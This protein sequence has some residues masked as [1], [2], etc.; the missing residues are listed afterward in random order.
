MTYPR[1]SLRV[2]HALTVLMLLSVLHLS[3]L[4]FTVHLLSL[5]TPSFLSKTHSLSFFGACLLP[6]S[7]LFHLSPS[8]NSLPVHFLLFMICITVFFF[9]FLPLPFLSKHL[10]NLALPPLCRPHRHSSSLVSLSLSWHREQA[11]TW[12]G[13]FV[14]QQVIPP[15]QWGG[16][17]GGGGGCGGWGGGGGGLYYYLLSYTFATSLRLQADGLSL[18]SHRQEVSPFHILR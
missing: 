8:F 2:E 1:L 3:Q 17:G 7:P 13:C 16:G 10:S 6:L 5:K 4:S 9:H 12:E 14:I 18:F 11:G 15:W